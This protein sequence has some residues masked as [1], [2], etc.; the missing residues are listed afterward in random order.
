MEDLYVGFLVPVEV[1]TFG[2]D[3][4]SCRSFFWHQSVGHTFVST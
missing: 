2:E 1:E 3:E 4:A